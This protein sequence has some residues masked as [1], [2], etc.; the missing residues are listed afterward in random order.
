MVVKKA[1]PTALHKAS[2]LHLVSLFGLKD[3]HLVTDVEPFVFNRL[4]YRQEGSKY[5]T[6]ALNKVVHKNEFNLIT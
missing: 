4:L 6:F 3:P 2:K 1:A 5:K